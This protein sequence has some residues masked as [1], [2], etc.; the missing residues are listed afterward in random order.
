[1]KLERLQRSENEKPEDSF[2]L[3]FDNECVCEM[4]YNVR[5]TE[6]ER[7]HLRLVDN[8]SRLVKMFSSKNLR[9]F[10]T[11]NINKYLL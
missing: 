4:L 1:M 6:R 5:K 11:V 8:R 7:E 2:L 3:F 10:E 9:S